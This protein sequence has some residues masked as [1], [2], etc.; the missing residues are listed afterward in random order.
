MSQDTSDL[1]SNSSQVASDGKADKKDAE[2][3]MQEFEEEEELD[4]VHTPEWKLNKKHVFILSEAGKPIYS[5]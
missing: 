3:R 5:R 4:Y 2:K 1:E